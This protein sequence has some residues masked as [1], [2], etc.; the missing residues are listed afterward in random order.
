MIWREYQALQKVVELGEQFVSYVDDGE[1]DLDP[2]V[3]I[4]GMPTWGYLWHR[5][6]GAFGARRVIIPDL[7]G[8]GFSDKSDTFDRGLASQAEMI[9]DLMEALGVERATIVGHDIGGGIALRLAT[10]F[11]DRVSRLCLMNSVCYD[12]WPIEAMIQLGHPQSR[13]K[14]SAAA[15]LATVKQA[16][17]S[18]FAEA[19]YDSITTGLFAPYATEA[20]KLSLI[21]NASALDTNHTTELTPL[22]SRIDVPTLIVWGEDDRFLPVNCA[23]W[24]AMDIPHAELV[25]VQDARH[26][27]MIDR[28]DEV[29]RHLSAFV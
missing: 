28:H 3:L 26:F 4:H 14:A 11:P 15:T 22:L 17:K 12:A 8:F 10:L 18:G 24:L 13:H 1:G 25:R 21:R 20:G 9:D 2:V 23:E 6:I 7:L 19:P 29:H 16:L 5:W 27:V